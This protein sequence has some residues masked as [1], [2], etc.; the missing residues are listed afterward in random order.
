MKALTGSLL[1][2]ALATTAVA[3]PP[4]AAVQCADVLELD[5]A[6]TRAFVGTIVPSKQTTVGNE[7]AGLGR[8]QPLGSKRRPANRR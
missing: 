2:L 6:D 8:Q 4:L 3:G 1:I 5:V 7:Y